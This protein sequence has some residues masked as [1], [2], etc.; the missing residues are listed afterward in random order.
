LLQSFIPII[1]V[2]AV[3]VSLAYGLDLI[4]H[5]HFSQAGLLLTGGIMAILR[6]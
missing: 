4:I 1:A 2:L 3:F 5:P 6:V